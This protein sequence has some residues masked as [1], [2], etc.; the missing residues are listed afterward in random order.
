[1]QTV[2][3]QVAP[4]GVNPVIHV[5]QYDVG[6]QFI[7]NLY[8]GSV[9]YS[10][11][12]GTTAQI[13]GIKPDHKGFSYTDAVSVS[14]NVVT[15]T[16]KEQM[17]VV[18]GT[19]ECEI[20]FKKSGL[21]IGTL[22]FKMIVEASPVN[23]DTDISETD[24]PDIIALAREQEKNAEA[25]ANGTKD[26]EP[27]GSSEPQYQNNSKYWSEVSD[28]FSEESEAWARGTKDGVDVSSGEA[29]YHNNSKYYSEESENHADR[30]ESW[31]KGTRDG[32]PVPSED[33]AYHN[34]SK[35]WA[36]DSFNHA[37]ISKTW[38]VGPN[39]DGNEG[40]DIN[41]SKY[42]SDMSHEYVQEVATYMNSISAI[43]ALIHL[44][45]GTIYTTT[46]SGDRLITESGDY[47]ILDF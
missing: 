25:W 27:V 38:A 17:T 12:A 1:M 15:V 4:N 3:L 46:E 24:I 26:G 31:A 43:M 44:L 32:E 10:L 11:P 35:Y 18:H 13:D 30:S 22:N 21:D 2:N 41:N 14:G 40:T 19:V 23:E 33:P 9:A 5:S 42:W 37:V 29:Q 8:D 47:L 28:D 16:T 7:L 6:R 39:G 36:T 45:F 20:R 34:H